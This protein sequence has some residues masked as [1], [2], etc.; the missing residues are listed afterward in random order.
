MAEAKVTGPGVTEMQLL[1]ARL[2]EADPALKRALRKN[3]KDAAAPLVRGVQKSILTMP[4][5]S[6]APARHAGHLRLEV[7]DTVV[8]RTSFARSGVRVNIDSLGRKMPQGKE[9]LP[10]HLDSEKGWN[11]PVFGRAAAEAESVALQKIHGKGFGHGRGWTWVKQFG[12][13]G[14]FERPITDGAREFRDAAL[15]AIDE[16]EKHLGA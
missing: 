2:K 16:V 14:W 4:S 5:R 15:A 13:P 6:T 11:H 12:K 10:R 3:F 9:T 7:A 8:L 1:A